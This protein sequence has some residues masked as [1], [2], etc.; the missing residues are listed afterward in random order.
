[1]ICRPKRSYGRNQALPPKLA[2]ERRERVATLSER[3]NEALRAL[4]A[5]TPDII[6]SLVVSTEGFVVSSL[7]P[8]EVD[9]ELVSGM[10]ASLLGVGERISADLMRS[11]MEQVYVRSPKGYIILNAVTNDTVLVLLVTRDAKLGLIFLE[12]KR[13]LAELSKAI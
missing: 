1:M 12:L 10:A 7:L 8:A 6:G 4:R 9:E 11:D 2:T 13:V 5:S 3:I